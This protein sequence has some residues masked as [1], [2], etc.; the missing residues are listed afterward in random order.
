MQ[1]VA[2]CFMF[3]SSPFFFYSHLM[4]RQFATHWGFWG[5]ECFRL[6][7][8][9]TAAPSTLQSR[10]SAGYFKGL[11]HVFH[12]LLQVPLLTTWKGRLCARLNVTS[13]AALSWYL[14]RARALRQALGAAYVVFEGAEGN[15]FLEQAMS[16]PAELAGDRYAGALA[17]AL[18]TL[19]NATV[20]SAGARWVTVRRCSG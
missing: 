17:A 2:Q 7:A 1:K 11:T 10:G 4:I 8:L 20:I 9:Q 5:A 15:A 13:E 6:Y 19:G 16:P 3:P 12:P 14:A 18:A